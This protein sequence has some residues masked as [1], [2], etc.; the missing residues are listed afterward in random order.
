VR[1]LLHQKLFLLPGLVRS[2]FFALH[3]SALRRASVVSGISESGVVANVGVDVETLAIF[4]RSK[5]ISLP[6]LCRR[7]LRFPV[8]RRSGHGRQCI[9]KSGM[10]ENVGVAAETASPSLSVQ[11]LFLL[12]VSSQ[13]LNSGSCIVG[14]HV[15]C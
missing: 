1:H 7:H 9:S 6:G 4:S 14:V 10:V 8:S 12:P 15:L 11:K 13:H 5:V 3:M 2:P